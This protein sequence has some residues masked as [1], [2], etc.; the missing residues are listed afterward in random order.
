[1]F[2]IQRLDLA[3]K[4]RRMTG[5]A[6][7]EKAG[8]SAVTVS[9]ILNEQQSPDQS[10][11]VALAKALGF[12]ESFF[13]K[14][15]AE[16]LNQNAASFRS[17][18]TMSARE[19]DAALAAGSL[20]FEM[21]DWVKAQFD[22]PVADFPDFDGQRTPAEAARELRQH[23][24]IGERPVRHMIR[25]LESKGIRVFSLAENTKNV[26]AYSCWK[27]GEPY[28]FLNTFKTTERSRFDAA[29]ELG[30]LVL[31]KHGG[32][33]GRDVEA[34]AQEFAGAFLMPTD[35]LLAQAPHI[36]TLSQ[37]IK[38]KARWGVSA[39]ALAYRLHKLGRIS[40]WNYRT[41]CIQLNRT[42]KNSEP[43]GLPPER[44]S[45]WQQVLTDLWKN[46][47]T[48]DRIADDLSFPR[49]EVETLLFGLTG[50][51]G[52]PDRAAPREG[53]RLV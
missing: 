7:A 39:A 25:L 29:H 16:E 36:T 19:R 20:A 11:I 43:A 26:D 24:G 15:T 4:R 41:F 12:P 28:V 45:V 18:S 35:D 6:L 50:E 48:R 44:S 21:C 10:T 22:L 51:V 3:R 9:R 27:D 1:M 32:P 8:L 38:T 5:K 40:D 13:F 46:G 47:V 33:T 34:E 49:E 14:D 53:L 23:W 42:Y 30:H 52:L 37:L 2:S 17:L 31:H